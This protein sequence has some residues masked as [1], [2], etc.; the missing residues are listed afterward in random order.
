MP[1]WTALPGAKTLPGFHGCPCGGRKPAGFSSLLSFYLRFALLPSP[2]LAENQSGFHHCFR[3][4]PNS[5][6]NSSG[7][8]GISPP[9]GGCAYPSGAQCRHKGVLC[10]PRRCRIGEG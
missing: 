9:Y 1:L 2:I 7:M 10:L 4:I 6:R 5:G 8:A 3:P